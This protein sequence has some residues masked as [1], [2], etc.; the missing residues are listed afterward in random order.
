M[1]DISVLSTEVAIL[2]WGREGF[3]ACHVPI[4]GRYAD[5]PRSQ[6]YPY[7]AYSILVHL[8]PSYSHF[9][10][11]TAFRKPV[12]LLLVCSHLD[13]IHLASTRIDDT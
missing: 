9:K 10:Y 11:S 8:F 1:L 7:S 13:R 2:A 6:A 12:A 4:I 5:F 3:L